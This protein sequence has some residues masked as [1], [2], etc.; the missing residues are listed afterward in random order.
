MQSLP[1]DILLTIVRFLPVRSTLQLK[2]S[3]KTFA[4]FRFPIPVPLKLE[5]KQS[6]AKFF[7]YG[8]QECVIRY[9]SHPN[10]NEKLETCMKH[11]Y[12]TEADMNTF[13]RFETQENE[14]VAVHCNDRKNY[15]ID[16]I[17][18]L[19]SMETNGWHPILF[20]QHVSVKCFCGAREG[21]VYTT[22]NDITKYYRDIR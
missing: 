10:L 21:Y 14:C 22:R 16:V 17:K 2:Q 13:I 18:Y 4:D 3:C 9:L 20:F 1:D 15:S 5:N 7:S 8:V 12:V 11:M 6:L 19:K